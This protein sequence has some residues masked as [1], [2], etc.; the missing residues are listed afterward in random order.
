MKTDQQVLTDNGSSD[1]R[2]RLHSLRYSCGCR[3]GTVALL[4]SLMASSYYFLYA[5]EAFYSNGQKLLYIFVV[6]LGGAAVGKIIEI[7]LS[8]ILYVLLKE[9]ITAS[10]A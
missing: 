9:R 5:A 6:C 10:A 4:L 3:G 2:T 8:R 1:W 7:S